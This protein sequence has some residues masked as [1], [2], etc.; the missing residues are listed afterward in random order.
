MATTKRKTHA[1]AV[2][3]RMRLSAEEARY[4]DSFRWFTPD[5]QWVLSGLLSELIF[6]STTRRDEALEQIGEIRSNIAVERSLLAA[7][8]GR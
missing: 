7:G 2:R 4:L 8:G 1:L 3:R 6:T 5:Q